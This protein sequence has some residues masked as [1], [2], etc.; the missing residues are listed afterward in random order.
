[1]LVGC[2]TELMRVLPASDYEQN[3]VAAKE[4]DLATILAAM[5]ILNRTDILIQQRAQGRLHAELALVQICSLENLDDLSSIVAWLR[6]DDSAS[7]KSAIHY[8]AP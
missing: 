4:L 3:L 5:Q 8:D 6:E 2:P 1:M 7:S